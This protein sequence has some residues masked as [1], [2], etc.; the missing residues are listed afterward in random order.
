MFEKDPIFRPQSF[1]LVEKLQVGINNLFFLIKFYNS[2]WIKNIF[3]R[4]RESDFQIA[5]EEIYKEKDILSNGPLK[6]GRYIVVKKLA[7]KLVGQMY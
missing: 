7:K 4:K 3:Q 5:Y 2:F 1:E 6:N